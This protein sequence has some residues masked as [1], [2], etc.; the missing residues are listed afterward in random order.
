MGMGAM[1]PQGAPPPGSPAPDADSP[2]K[3]LV[4]MGSEIDRALSALAQ[5]LPKSDG[6]AQARRLIA[7][8][9]AAA[10]TGGDIAASPTA[11]GSQFPGS[12]PSAPVPRP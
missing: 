9:I 3:A 11:A 6:I 4:A 10:L 8:D 2:D 1:T 7:A 12:T 5:V